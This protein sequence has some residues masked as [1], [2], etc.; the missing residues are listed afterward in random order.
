MVVGAS[1][2]YPRENG[3][4]RAIKQGGQSKICLRIMNLQCS[5]V[6]TWNHSIM[7]VRILTG[8]TSPSTRRKMYNQF[9]DPFP[10]EIF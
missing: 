8:G 3:E 1:T 9:S 2:G 6:P 10:L 7:K 5:E 4:P